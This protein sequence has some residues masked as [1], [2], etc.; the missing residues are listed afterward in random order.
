M[1]KVNDLLENNIT[2][3]RKR[4][5]ELDFV[6]GIILILVTFDHVGIFGYYWPTVEAPFI[7]ASNV[8]GMWLRDFMYR[9][10]DSSI[11]WA[12]EPT[13]IWMLVML[14]GVNCTFSRNH[15]RRAAEMLALDIAIITLHSV[16]K[17]YAPDTLKG[18]TLFN[19]LTIFALSFT[20][21][22]FIDKFKVKNIYLIEAGLLLIA[23]GMYYYILHRTTLIGPQLT[24]AKEWDFL[25]FL[26]YNTNAYEISFNNFEPLLPSLGFFLLGGV[27]GRKFYANRTSL[28]NIERPRFLRP[29]IWIGRHSLS[30]FL[31][32]AFI[33]VAFMWFLSFIK[34]L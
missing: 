12:V 26:V 6:R 9:Y 15:S 23:A 34:I 4:I 11:R 1:F 10:L 33:V 3:K 32:G 31:F 13:I 5:W 7:G 25:F 16:V 28:F 14:S 2:V 20:L 27:F 17:I 18:E 19:I 21:W 22:Y 30:I 24:L 29:V 8:F